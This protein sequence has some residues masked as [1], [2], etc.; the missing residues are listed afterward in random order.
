MLSLQNS[1]DNDVQVTF[2]DY[3]GSKNTFTF[4]HKA[5]SSAGGFSLQ[6]GSAK[7]INIVENATIS[8]DQYFVTDA[9]QFGH[10]YKVT[11]VNADGTSSASI[12]L[13]D[14]MSGT[15]L[16]VTLGT[17]NADQK[18]ID[19]QS[20]YFQAQSSSTFTVTWGTGAA[21][22]NTG[23]YV[24]AFPTIKTQ[25]GGRLALVAPNQSV[26]LRD[27]QNLSLPTGAVQANIWTDG[28]HAYLNLTAANREDGTTSSGSVSNF[29]IS[30][31]AT[32]ATLTLGRTSTGGLAYT[33]QA[34]GYVLPNQSV[35]LNI[36]VNSAAGTNVTQPAILLV[37]EKDDAG[38]EYSVILPVTTEASGSNN[39]AKADAPTFTADEDSSTL[40]SNSDITQYVDLW[41]TFAER[42]SNGQDTIKV[43]Y[44]DDQVTARVLVL[45]EGATTSTTGSTG[46]S[47]VQESVPITTAVARL[48]SEVQAD[49]AAKTTKN[50]ILVGGPVVNSLVAELA[51]AAKTWDRQMYLDNGEGTYVLDYVDN[52]FGGGKAALVVAGH[53]AADSRASSKMLVNPTGLTGM[54]MAWKNGVV[55]A[56][57]V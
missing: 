8:Q 43:Y 55:L 32:L 30:D 20:Y 2:T 37:E 4:A 50:L 28:P 47:T 10:I 12:G 45:A 16:T 29:N 48:D 41:G 23:S 25:K 49:Q 14:V 17:D 54:R 3:R 9:G 51:S 42:N 18:V 40:G 6:D 1:G 21:L 53:S 13:T 35:A 7:A 27:G 5:T 24:T 57:A 19:G 11:S 34:S 15:T 31:N 33:L 26:V 56:D 38:N 36:T 44:P 39:V 46:G 22:N 52:A